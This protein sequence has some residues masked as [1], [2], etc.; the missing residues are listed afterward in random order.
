LGTRVLRPVEKIIRA[1]TFQYPTL[2][3]EKHAVGF[4]DHGDDYVRFALIE[5]EARILQAICGIKVVLKQP[6]PR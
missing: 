3:H 5:N 2:I 1:W 4:G 6:L